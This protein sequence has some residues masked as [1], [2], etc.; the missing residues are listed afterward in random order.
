MVLFGHRRR[1]H[2]ASTTETILIQGKNDDA[3]RIEPYPGRTMPQPTAD[4]SGGDRCCLDH[5]CRHAGRNPRLTHWHSRLTPACTHYA[6]RIGTA[7]TRSLVWSRPTHCGVYQPRTM[8]RPAGSGR[9][10]PVIRMSDVTPTAIAPTIA[11]TTC[12]TGD[13]IA[14][15]AMPSVAA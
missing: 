1:P 8:L 4:R 11:K 10:I 3:R 2:N 6:S 9:A 5:I 14:R 13:G 15:R 12:H 7:K